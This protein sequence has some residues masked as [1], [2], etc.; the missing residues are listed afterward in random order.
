MTSEGD[1]EDTIKIEEV[2]VFLFAYDIILFIKHHNDSMT[3]TAD[4]YIQ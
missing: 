2:R 3:P 1:Q 4:Q